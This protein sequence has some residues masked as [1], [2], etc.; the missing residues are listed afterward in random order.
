MYIAETACFDCHSFVC[1][2]PGEIVDTVFGKVTLRVRNVKDYSTVFY[3]FNNASSSS[4]RGERN[5]VN[6]LSVVH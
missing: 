4:A 1:H 3:L 6:I 5:A 2:F